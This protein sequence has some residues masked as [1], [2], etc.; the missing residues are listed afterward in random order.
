MAFDSSG[1]KWKLKYNFPARWE[2]RERKGGRKEENKG[3]RE[4]ESTGGRGGR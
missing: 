2:V 3:G 1:M 4:E